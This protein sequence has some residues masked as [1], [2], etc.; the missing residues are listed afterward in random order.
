MVPDRATGTRCLRRVGP[1]DYLL[2]TLF[3]LNPPPPTL[4][5]RG[6]PPKRGPCRGP[7]GSSARDERTRSYP[8]GLDRYILILISAAYSIT[9]L[10]LQLYRLGYA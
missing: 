1:A 2:A 6:P 8:E 9:G 3:P 7:T 5:R 10:V 4:L